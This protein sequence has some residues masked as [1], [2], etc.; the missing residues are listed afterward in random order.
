[1]QKYGLDVNRHYPYFNT[2]LRV[3]TDPD[4]MVNIRD[5]ILDY[6]HWDS[7][8]TSD[9]ETT[10]MDS[11][12]Y[13]TV[14]SLTTLTLKVIFSNKFLG[15]LPKKRRKKIK[16]EKVKTEDLFDSMLNVDME[17]EFSSNIDNIIST[18]DTA[19][20]DDD[21]DDEGEKSILCGIMDISMPDFSSEKVVSKA[22]ED[23]DGEKDV[24]RELEELFG[25]SI[26]IKKTAEDK[27]KENKT[28]STTDVNVKSSETNVAMEENKDETEKMDV[29]GETDNSEGDSKVTSDETTRNETKIDEN[30]VD[31]ATKKITEPDDATSQVESSESKGAT[32]DL[33][34]SAKSSSDS[35]ESETVKDIISKDVNNVDATENGSTNNSNEGIENNKAIEREPAKEN[36]NDKYGD[37]TETSRE[38][39][40]EQT[41]ESYVESQ[42]YTENFDDYFKKDES[43]NEQKV[44]ENH[45]AVDPSLNDAASKL[46]DKTPEIPENAS[47]T[48]KNHQNYTTSPTKQKSEDFSI[49]NLL[50][51]TEPVKTNRP[52][53]DETNISN[54]GNENTVT[55]DMTDSEIEDERLMNELNAQIGETEDIINGKSV[56]ELSESEQQKRANKDTALDLD[57]VSDE[58]F[59]FDT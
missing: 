48:S 42:T 25:T 3:K 16:E 15:K 31:D 55:K 14:E 28:N 58:E 49:K 19:W 21:D 36:T 10:S 12:R 51:P 17:S 9:G 5:E 1:M 39:K 30:V 52:I 4:G 38:E 59:N 8:Y 35:V 11:S 56:S 33:P 50:K 44:D 41:S 57:N 40:T 13:K 22:D 26:S 43:C 27:N 37:D 2:T 45:A 24:A 6:V 23:V 20:G 53:E 18:L 54:G 29:D 32:K 34:E 47:E 7:D 46:T